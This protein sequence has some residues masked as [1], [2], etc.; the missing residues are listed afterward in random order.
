MP[1]PAGFDK[2]LP[3]KSFAALNISATWFRASGILDFF[4]M[5]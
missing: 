5:V 3:N 1:L 4:G 2:V